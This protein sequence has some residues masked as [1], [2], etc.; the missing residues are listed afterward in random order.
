MNV[1]V[2]DC[3]LGN[4]LLIW[5]RITQAQKLAIQWWC[6]QMAW[7]WRSWC[8]LPVGITFLVMPSEKVWYENFLF[9]WC[10]ALSKGIANNFHKYVGP[11]ELKLSSNPPS[12]THT[13]NNT[14]FMQ[15]AMRNNNFPLIIVSAPFIAQ[16]NRLMHFENVCSLIIAFISYAFMFDQNFMSLWPNAIIFA[17]LS[18]FCITPLNKMNICAAQF[19]ASICCLQIKRKILVAICR[20]IHC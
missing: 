2:L 13:L 16:Q 7:D 3:S 4:W 9:R 17:F 12:L 20:H 19:R 6:Y 15:L 14:I 1:G 8:R 11:T 18:I 10:N 5:K